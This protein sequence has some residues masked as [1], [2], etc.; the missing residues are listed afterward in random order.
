MGPQRGNRVQPGSVSLL[1]EKCYPE[2]EIVFR[3]FHNSFRAV[4]RPPSG[5]S[6]LSI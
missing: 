2:K 1:S 6:D 4:V 5:K 3:S